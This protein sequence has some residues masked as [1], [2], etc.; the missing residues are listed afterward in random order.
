M[1]SESDG[2]S[3]VERIGVGEIDAVAVTE[4]HELMSVLSKIGS[5]AFLQFVLLG[6]LSLA[7]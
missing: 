4:D 1:S 2:G 3:R 7:V 6:H 5:H